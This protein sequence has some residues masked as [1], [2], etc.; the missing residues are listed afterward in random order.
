MIAGIFGL[1]AIAASTGTVATAV[2]GI[3]GGKAVNEIG[4]EKERQ[5]NLK[6]TQEQNKDYQERL[7]ITGENE[8]K[9][10]EIRAKSEIDTLNANLN[11]AEEMKRIN[12]E[13]EIKKLTLDN[14]KTK[15]LN[16]HNREVKKIDN[17]PKKQ[18]YHKNIFL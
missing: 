1:G 16:T 15:E 3:V 12:D 4:K 10:L 17:L 18:F 7:R 5:Y 8:R 14:E 13:T 2:A 6:L 9:L 11:H